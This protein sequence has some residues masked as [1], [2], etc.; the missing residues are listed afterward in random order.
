MASSLKR[1]RG[2]DA[3]AA[4]GENSL[5]KLVRRRRGDVEML[6]AHIEHLENEVALPRL[7]R[8]RKLGR[9][10]TVQFF[11]HIIDLST[12]TVRSNELTAACHYQWRFVSR[13]WELW[14][15]LWLLS[16]FQSFAHVSLLCRVCL[17]KY[18]DNLFLE[19]QTLDQSDVKT[20]D[21]YTYLK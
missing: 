16:L 4:E 13:I 1:A 17:C 21:Q 7:I 11:W 6:M 10:L 15:G 19:Q 20:L 14:S 12:T 18:I 9:L 2:Q 3:E 5:V 8:G